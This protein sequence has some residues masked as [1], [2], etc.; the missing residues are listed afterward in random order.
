M[1]NIEVVYADNSQVHVLPLQVTEGSNVKLAIELSGILDICP[2]IDFEINKIG[3][4]STVCELDTVVENGDRIEI[5]RPLINDPKDARRK[6]AI[7][8]KS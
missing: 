3:I 1:F 6:R 2:E 5:Y 7:A 8:E 4:F